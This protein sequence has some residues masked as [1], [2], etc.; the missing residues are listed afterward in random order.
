MGEPKEVWSRMDRQ[1]VVLG[2][3]DK[4]YTVTFS[5]WSGQYYSRIETAP[6]ERPSL[7]G[8]TRIA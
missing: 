7:E 1:L 6:I 8:Y 5:W 4:W 2:E 3:D